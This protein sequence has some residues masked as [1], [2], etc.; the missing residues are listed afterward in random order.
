MTL[1]EE[2]LACVT[3]AEKLVILAAKLIPKFV[4]LLVVGSYDYMAKSI[5]FF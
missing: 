3:F 4:E 5:N 2:T 1:R